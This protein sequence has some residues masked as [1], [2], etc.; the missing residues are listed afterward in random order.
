M[1]VRRQLVILQQEEELRKWDSYYQELMEYTMNPNYGRLK[2]FH[3]LLSSDCDDPIFIG[4]TG[5]LPKV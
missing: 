2:C 4:I 1:Y 5:R 3:C